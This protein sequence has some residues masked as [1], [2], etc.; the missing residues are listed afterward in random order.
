MQLIRLTNNDLKK[1]NKYEIDNKIVNTESDIYLYSNKELLKI[2]KTKDLLL[3][4][5]Y[6]LNKLFYIK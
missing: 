6:V 2:I 1:I 5:L 3:S 4:K